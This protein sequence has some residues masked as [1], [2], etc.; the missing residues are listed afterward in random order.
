MHVKRIQKE[1]TDEIERLRKVEQDLIR[2]GVER[3][4][5]TRNG[6]RDKEKKIKSG[7]RAEEIRNNGKD[8]K[9]ASS[10][11]MPESENEN[12]R[13]RCSKQGNYYRYYIGNKYLNKSQM[14]LAIK[15]ANR[16][17][18]K[19]LLQPIRTKISKLERLLQDLS[20]TWD[21]PEK[22][23]DKLH[24]AR[25]RLVDPIIPPTEE[26]IRR[27]LEEPYDVWEILDEDVSGEFY[28]QKGER[29]RSKSELII[30]DAL[31]RYGIPYKYE[32]PLKLNNGRGAIT[33][34]PDFV[35]LNITSLEM[36]IIE[37]LGMLDQERYYRNSID[38]IDLYERN[39]YMIGKNLI[40]L[41]ETSYSALNTGTVG[42]YIEQ[43]LL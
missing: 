32:Y 14:N 1:L 26:Y 34:R 24:P 35:A 27:W 7:S 40:L 3:E 30:A 33:K 41:H 5:Y 8:R 22:V 11:D 9:R 36:V 37:H 29:V 19:K 21:E 2:G 13:L 25:K 6:D 31:Y 38:K 17:Y 4:I 42:R 39:G 20:C 23:Y 12:G 18:R 15:A 10:A 16:E 43:F 28:T